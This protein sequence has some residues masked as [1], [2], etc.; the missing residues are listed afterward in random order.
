M[1]ALFAVTTVLMVQKNAELNKQKK[2][3]ETKLK[4]IELVEKTLENLPPKYFRY[5]SKLRRHELG[6]QPKFK[7]REDVIPESD[8]KYLVEA[9]K[10]LRNTIESIRKQT[11]LDIKFTLLIEGMSSKTSYGKTS[12][13]NSRWEDNETLS[14]RRA[15]S[16]L[17]LWK[18]NN[19]NFEDDY[20]DLQVAGSGTGG[21][22]RYEGKL[23]RL[24]QR[25][26]IQI[27]PKVGDLKK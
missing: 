13:P 5:N 8:R 9:G 15:L 22:E 19:V 16:L 7:D 14:Y 21:L 18:Q 4:E 26:M 3:F 24:N 25:I 12:C 6:M 20:C 27:L 11:K 2:D 10:D 1:V 17:N 23:E